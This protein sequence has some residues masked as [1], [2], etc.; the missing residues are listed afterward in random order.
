MEYGH[1]KE[2]KEAIDMAKITLEAMY[3]GGIFDHIGYGF[4]RYSVDEKWLVPHF[5]KKWL[6]D[7]ALLAIAYTKAYEITKDSFH[8]EVAEKKYLNLF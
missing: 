6:Y 1:N 2:D 3:K 8:K 5:E 7:N 4:Y